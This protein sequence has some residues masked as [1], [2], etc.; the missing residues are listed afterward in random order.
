MLKAFGILVF[1]AVMSGCHTQE[2]VNSSVLNSSDSTS[3]VETLTIDTIDVPSEQLIIEVPVFIR[4]TVIVEKEGRV[5]TKIVYRDGVI[6][7][8]AKCDSLQELVVSR[9]R[10]VSHFKSL[11]SQK[12]RAEKTSKKRDIPWYYKLALGYAIVQLIIQIIKNLL[13]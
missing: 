5:S 11:L 3:G 10:E 13:L 1:I 6:S 8:T 4:D 2:L 12:D 9:N 7:V